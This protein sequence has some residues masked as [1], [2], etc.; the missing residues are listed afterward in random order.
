M[1][2]QES[3]AAGRLHVTDVFP[4]ANP[5]GE[6]KVQFD[7]S[8]LKINEGPQHELLATSMM[9]EVKAQFDPR[10]QAN[11]PWDAPKAQLITRRGFTRTSGGWR[12]TG[13]SSEIFI[14]ISRVINNPV[15]DLIANDGGREEHF[16]RVRHIDG[17]DHWKINSGGLGAGT[18]R[19]KV[20]L[21]VNNMIKATQVAKHTVGNFYCATLDHPGSRGLGFG[22]I[23][24]EASEGR[25]QLSAISLTRGSIDAQPAAFRNVE[26]TEM[27]IKKSLCWMHDCLYYL[28]CE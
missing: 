10:D 21:S 18:I 9:D 3:T 5:I 15:A 13:E 2:A 11:I 28:T 20:T 6:V 26:I 25:V 19:I 17:T 8:Q 23:P 7:P 14:L 1:R 16:Y 24:A 12:R 22:I 27:M 4:I